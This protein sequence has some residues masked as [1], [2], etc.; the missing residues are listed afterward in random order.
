M[1]PWQRIDLQH[2]GSAFGIA[3]QIDAPRIATPEGS[4]SGNGRP[5]CLSNL[6]IAGVAISIINQL[7]TPILVG[8]AVGVR[9]C[10][11]SQ[12]DL[13]GSERLGVSPASE[14]ADGEFAARQIG[15]DEY[16]LVELVEQPLAHLRELG[17]ARDSG[18][19]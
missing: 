13:E 1:Q 11:S 2:L 19:R 7:Y 8:V 9:I 10:M 12:R 6:R 18:G 17:I 5:L 16:R 15:L 4:P 14:N 3:A